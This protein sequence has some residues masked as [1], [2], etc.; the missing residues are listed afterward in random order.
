MI[1]II[2]EILAFGSAFIIIDWFIKTS[3]EYYKK[4]QNREWYYGFKGM[5]CQM[6]ILL[7]QFLFSIGVIIVAM[8]ASGIDVSIDSIIK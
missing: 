8:I 5:F 3:W 1:Q 7:I 6:I 2:K 4:F